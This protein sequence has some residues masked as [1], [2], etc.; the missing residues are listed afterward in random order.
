MADVWSGWQAQAGP[1]QPAPPVPGTYQIVTETGEDHETED[2]AQQLPD[3]PLF[4][5]IGSLGSGDVLDVYRLTLNR[6]ARQLD[7]GLL[8]TSG[9]PIAP[10]RLQIFDESG[11]LLASWELGQQGPALHASVSNIPA[12]TTI[13]LGVGSGRDGEA[14]GDYQLWVSNTFRVPTTPSSGL[15]PILPAI[16]QIAP[17]WSGLPVPPTTATTWTSPRVESGTSAV[18]DARPAT[19]AA[20]DLRHAPLSAGVVSQ[21]DESVPPARDAPPE[22]APRPVRVLSGGARRTGLDFGAEAT[23][24][25]P[26]DETQVAAATTPTRVT[27]SG[28]VGGFPV[29][30]V[31]VIGPVA[32]SGT[33]LVSIDLN[34][35]DAREMATSPPAPAPTTALMGTSDLTIP[36]FSG[37]GMAMAWSLNAFLSQPASGFDCYKAYFDAR[38]RADEDETE[39]C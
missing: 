14:A 31:A 21:G 17:L 7:L 33:D 11:Q 28:E 39:E 30:G 15:A 4:G 12:G 27:P 2:D 18:P 20:L 6:G 37:S 13:Y 16:T 29:L 26:V 5:V 32:S 8:A 35:L 23:G 9:Q 25:L 3:S 24:S 19:A 38:P 34:E 10:M 22:E 36:L 1:R